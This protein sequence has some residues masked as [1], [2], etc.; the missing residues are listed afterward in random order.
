MSKTPG[1][2]ARIGKLS[3][4]LALLAAAAVGTLLAQ[5]A[6]EPPVP[7]EAPAPAP[8][9]AP[10]IER[11][12]VVGNHRLTADAFVFASG[13]KVGDRYDPAEIKKAFKRLWD[14]DLFLDL[15]VEADD[16]VKGKV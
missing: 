13:I 4:V 3:L 1:R 7:A 10:T 14:K 5:D 9:E 11:I 8:A 15:T 6:E 12:E 16:G 2:R